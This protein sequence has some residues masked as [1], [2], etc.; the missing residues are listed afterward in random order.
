MTMPFDEN[1]KILKV[2][3]EVKYYVPMPHTEVIDKDT[4]EPMTMINGWPMS[5]VKKDWFETNDINVGHATRNS[6]EIGNSKKIINIEEMDESD[7]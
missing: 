4:G 6:Y 7:E 3:M 1:F 2:T 5:K